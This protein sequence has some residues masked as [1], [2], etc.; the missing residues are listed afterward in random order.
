MGGELEGFSVISIEATKITNIASL[1][2]GG[3][4]KVC[5]VDK[6][7]NYTL[8]FKICK[9]SNRKPT[10]NFKTP[11]LQKHMSINNVSPVTGNKYETAR[12]VYDK[13]I[14]WKEAYEILKS[15]EQLIPTYS[16]YYSEFMDVEWDDK[17][18][19]FDLLE[20]CQ[21]KIS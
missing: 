20:I 12:E 10:G 16:P 13:I 18:I 9:D 19:F 3:S 11:T 7:S 17:P 8:M 15:M 21:G 5:F 1:C 14:T 6:F 4:K 2:D